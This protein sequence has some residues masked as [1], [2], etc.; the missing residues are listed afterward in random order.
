MVANPS[1]PYKEHLVTVHGFKPSSTHRS[2]M[3][4]LVRILDKTVG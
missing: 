4:L 3:K 2:V 1:L